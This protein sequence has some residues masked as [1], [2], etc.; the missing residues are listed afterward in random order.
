MSDQLEVLQLTSDAKTVN[1]CGSE[2][3]SPQPARDNPQ[4]I[5]TEVQNY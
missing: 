1:C 3:G 4:T 2:P 5:R